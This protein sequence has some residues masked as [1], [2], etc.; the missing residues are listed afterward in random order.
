MAASRQSIKLGIL[1]EDDSDVAVLTHVLRKISPSKRFGTNKFVGRGCGKL[2]SK[3]RSWA[4]VL[5]S[6]RCSILIVFNDADGRN[7]NGLRAAIQ[8]A[9]CPSP[10]S[11]YIIIIPIEEVEA[12]LLSDP[13]AL[14][15]TFN[16]QRLPSCPAN[17]ERIRRP[18][19]YLREL[20]WKAS[21]HS[22]RYVNT[23]HNDRIAQHVSLPSLRKCRAF[24]PLQTFWRQV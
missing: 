6:K 11:P 19:E 22:K 9:L 12:W 4:T 2:Q 5:A 8:A 21:N 3:C 14:K 20:I 24:L 23:I 7:S 1:A 18:K 17:P 15:M 16:L 10:I 13:K